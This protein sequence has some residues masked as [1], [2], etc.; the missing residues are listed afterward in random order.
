[1][2]AVELMTSNS[3]RNCGIIEMENRSISMV[4]YDIYDNSGVENCSQLIFFGNDGESN[5]KC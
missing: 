2:W 4:Y 3:I 1:M 5:S